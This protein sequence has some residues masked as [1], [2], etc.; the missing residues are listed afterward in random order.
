[1]K[2]ALKLIL[3]TA[4]LWPLLAVGAALTTAAE[5]SPQYPDSIKAPQKASVSVESGGH[6][7][8]VAKSEHFLRELVDRVCPLAFK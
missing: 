8:V 6:V 1:M 4:R 2:A 3:I 5:N 7:A